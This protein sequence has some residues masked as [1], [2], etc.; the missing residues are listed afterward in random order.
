M[1]LGCKCFFSLISALHHLLS[2]N[3]LI[4]RSDSMCRYLAVCCSV[5]WYLLWEWW[6][7]KLDQSRFSLK[8]EFTS[9]QGHSVVSS[10]IIMIAYVRLE[11]L[12]SCP[13]HLRSMICAWHHFVYCFWD[14]L[15][16]FMEDTWT[17]NISVFSYIW[18]SN[19]SHK[20][21]ATSSLKQLMRFSF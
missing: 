16:Y 11:I 21:F 10:V 6:V 2:V 20:V 19:F 4:F 5:A 12:I 13:F 1:I 8:H 18:S 3:E 14:Y 17:K 9:C 7:F 15:L